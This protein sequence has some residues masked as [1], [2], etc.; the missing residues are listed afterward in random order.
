M[1]FAFGKALAALTSPANLLLLLALAGVLGM[2]RRWGRGL[3]FL[4][5][6][7]FMTIAVTPLATW[8]LLPLEQR[9]PQP[10]PEALTGIDGVIV[11]GGAIMPVASA[12]HGS[13]QLTRDAERM[14]VLPGLMRQLPGIPV[15]F[16]G[17][18]GDPRRPDAREA[19]FAAA[20]FRDWGLD[21]GRLFYEGASRNTWENAVNSRPL[22]AGGRWLLVTSAAHMPRSMGVFRQ[23]MP[24]VTFVAF[25]VGYEASRSEAWRFGL[26]LSR[27]ITVMET[28]AHEWRGLLAYRLS[29]RIAT[30]LPAP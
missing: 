19:P 28:A 29:G 24:G 5:V 8:L 27:N 1:D 26:N 18:S 9:F 14:T 3:L 4:S 6:A 23:V 16:T 11:L 10:G 12:E 2:G 17:G 25:P 13:P 7:G 30:L 21:E 15:V 22:V 20:L